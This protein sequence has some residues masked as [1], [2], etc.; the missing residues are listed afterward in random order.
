MTSVVYCRNSFYI[1]CRCYLSRSF[2]RRICAQTQDVQIFKKCYMSQM[3]SKDVFH[4]TAYS[5]QLPFIA[6]HSLS[7]LSSKYV[8]CFELFSIRLKRSF[9]EQSHYV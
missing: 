1:L 9:N 6:G 4:N 5:V 8:A 2:E 3:N 7:R